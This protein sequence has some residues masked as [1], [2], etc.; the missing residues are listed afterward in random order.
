MLGAFVY[1]SAFG[2]SRLLIDSE[3]SA[4][5]RVIHFHSLED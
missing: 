4:A 5:N 1:Q 2:N 3:P